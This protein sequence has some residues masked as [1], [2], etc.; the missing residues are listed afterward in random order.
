MAVPISYNI[1]GTTAEGNVVRARVSYLLR[2]IRV[3]FDYENGIGSPD[4]RVLWFKIGGKRNAK[5]NWLS[6]L[7]HKFLKGMRIASRW[8]MQQWFKIW[9]KN[10]VNVDDAQLHPTALAK[11]DHPT[12]LE[13]TAEATEKQKNFPVNGASLDIP[14]ADA[15]IPGNKLTLTETIRNL[16]AAIRNFPVTIRNVHNNFR[17]K[18]ENIKSTINTVMTYPNRKIVTRLTVDLL[19]RQ[20][21]LLKPKKIIVHGTVGFAD[22]AQTATIMGVY[23]VAAEVLNLRQNINIAADLHAA[24]FAADLNFQIKGR[25]SMLLHIASI[26]RFALRKPIRQLIFDVIQK[27]K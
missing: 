25:V 5:K 7:W 23:A 11:H 20:L 4:I 1:E 14:P 24:N 21:Q 12:K 27:S 16:I 9:R 8:S 19:K 22:P 17:K 6:M 18:I 3:K 13:T 15:A 2:L 10:G 26:I